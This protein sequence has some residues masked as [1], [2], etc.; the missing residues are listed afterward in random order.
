MMSA[1]EVGNARPGRSLC[2]HVKDA[3]LFC[4]GCRAHARNNVDLGHAFFG[5]I[6]LMK[7][8]G[9]VPSPWACREAYSGPQVPSISLILSCQS[10]RTN[11]ANTRR[12]DTCRTLVFSLART[13]AL[14][15]LEFVTIPLGTATTCPRVRL[16]RLYDVR[17]NDK[18]SAHMKSEIVFL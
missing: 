12:S 6:T 8:C 4:T 18:A 14:R 2:S 10:L 9:L 1:I 11:T 17:G 3:R 7:H 13:Q 16:Q 15:Q 5:L